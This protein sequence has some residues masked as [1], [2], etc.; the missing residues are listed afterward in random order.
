MRHS[1]TAYFWFDVTEEHI[2]RGLEKSS[3]LCLSMNCGAAVALAECLGRI[4]RVDVPMVREVNGVDLGRLDSASDAWTQEFDYC[5]FHKGP[6]PKPARLLLILDK[7]I[8][9]GDRP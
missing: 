8:L 6:R 1:L 3:A 2:T 4:V 7:P 5:L 9:E